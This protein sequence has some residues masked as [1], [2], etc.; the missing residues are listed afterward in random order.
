MKGIIRILAVLLLVFSVGC[1]SSEVGGDDSAAGEVNPPPAGDVE[2]EPEGEEA[3]NEEAPE[4][5]SYNMSV[6]DHNI[7]IKKS[8]LGMKLIMMPTLVAMS[9]PYTTTEV[10]GTKIV[11]FERKGD[12]VYL[13]EDMEGRT[14]TDPYKPANLIS[15]FPILDENDEGITFDFKKG[16]D[17]I[18]ITWG[19]Y[20]D[21]ESPNFALPVAASYLEEFSTEEKLFSVNHIA[22]AV[23]PKAAITLT[24]NYTFLPDDNADFS[25]LLPDELGRYGYFLTKPIYE[26]G[27]GEESHFVNRWDI[28]KP[29]TFYVSANTPPEYVDSVKEGILAW[30]ESFGR[31]IV[32]AEMA[33]E[34][35]IS[36][37]PRYNVVQW[38]GFDEAGF[39]YASWHAHPRTGEI[40]N[41]YVIMTSVFAISGKER[42]KK[43]LEQIEKNEEAGKPEAKRIGLAGFEV[44][45]LCD[46]DFM[47]SFKEFLGV[48]A[49]GEMTD[50]RIVEIS[51]LYVRAVVMHEVGHDLGLRHNFY[52]NLGS[53][54][55]PEA[56]REPLA[57]VLKGE[58]PKGPLPS[59]SIMDYLYFQDDILM[60]KPG[61]Y[62]DMA[63][64]WAYGLDEEDKSSPLYCTDGDVGLTVDCER[65]DGGSDPVI[66]RQRR[67]E[68]YVSDVS[69]SIDKKYFGAARDVD[70]PSAWAAVQY[71]GGL[72]PYLD[73]SKKVL[74]IGSF[75]AN[76]RRVGASRIVSEYLGASDDRFDALSILVND[77][78]YA[79][80][81]SSDPQVADQVLD[82]LRYIRYSYVSQL[83]A[84]ISSL[85]MG[86]MY[87]DDRVQKP[88]FFTDP[89]AIK[90]IAG[91]VG[92]IVANHVSVM[93]ASEPS[94]FRFY[95]A[96]IF[97]SLDEGI[98]FDIKK[99]T[100]SKIMGNIDALNDLLKKTDSGD[101]RARIENLLE[102][103]TTLLSIIGGG[104]ADGP[105]I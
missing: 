10:F 71:L 16:F 17:N 28:A 38:V 2:P 59:S 47:K 22:Q 14:V 72:V 101:E 37:D 39:A 100:T 77:D 69:R 92:T 55:P 19:D 86:W 64:R 52:G 85:T 26:R 65:F 31:N 79:K 46:M 18:I 4:P 76:E 44:S 45:R 5:L 54:I 98:V 1:S 84:G 105:R 94:E 91:A 40:L 6:V 51:K 33:P 81:I 43:L 23:D 56:D 96:Y 78:V 11:Y 36:G 49:S 7:V 82:Y 74:D 61:K 62:D 48:A 21:G 42:A 3:P 41:A 9:D 90:N 50:E 97:A 70:M 104:L 58:S 103:E 93:E 66:W 99:A 83:L 63:I 80:I 27:T 13:M 35:V 57:R 15:Q 8:I 24:F 95:A 53:E 89:R 34:G 68:D 88:S 73:S 30:N 67:L 29:M 32:K 75:S 60:H 25:Q 102:E 12:S 87:G 20:H